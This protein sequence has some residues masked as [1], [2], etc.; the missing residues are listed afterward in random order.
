VKAAYQVA[1]PHVDTVIVGAGVIGLVIARQLALSGRSPMLLETAAQFGSE[2]SSRNSEVIHSGI[3]YPFESLKSRLCIEGRANLYSYLQAHDIPYRK[4]GK[5]VFAS[6]EN[7][8]PTLDNIERMALAAGV[9]DVR[10]LRSS[11]VAI[12]EPELPCVEALLVPDTGIVDSH[13]YMQALLG[14]A[15]ANGAQFI[16]RVHVTRLVP[17]S[18]GWAIYI[19]GEPAPV[20]TATWVVNAAG[21]TAHKLAAQTEGLQ[22]RH[23]PAV[24]YARGCYFDYD[25]AVPF[26]HLIYPVPVVGGLG[27]HLTLDLRGRARF[28]PDV[29]WIDNINYAVDARKHGAFLT[30]ARLIWPQIQGDRLV[31][32]YAGIRPKLVG[33]GEPDA[34]FI[35]SSEVDHSVKGLI[36]LFGIESPGLTASLAIASHIYSLMKNLS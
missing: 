18:A 9:T 17:T 19:E 14:E 10:R 1:H 22:P 7:Q 27:T 33:P 4:T 30:A 13:R 6:R 24:R 26:R 21:L 35:I 29:E 3:Y 31:P 23:I 34:D 20:L 5:L 16:P 32:A 12:I 36:N 11:A 15:E 25:G 8:V 2:T 28:G